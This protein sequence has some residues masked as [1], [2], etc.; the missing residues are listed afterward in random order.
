MKRLLLFFSL[1]FPLNIVISQII[2]V[3]T[4]SKLTS[5]L[6]DTVW[7]PYTSSGSFNADNFFAVQLSNSQGVFSTFTNIGHD[8]A[9]SDSIPMV[10][11]GSGDQWVVR[12]IATDP[13]TISS[14]VSPY[15]RV[16]NYP[17]PSPI[18][19]IKVAAG[20]PTAFVG[21]T[22]HFHD[23]SGEPTGSKFLWT[24][25]QDA[26][27]FVSVDTSPKVTY[28]TIGTKSA[29]LSVSNSTGCTASSSFGLRI[30]T[31]HPIIPDSI[32]IVT[33]TESG[34]FPNVWIKAG[35][36]YIM[37]NGSRVDVTIFAEPGGSLLADQESTGIYYLKTG[38]SFIYGGN[39]R[40][41][42]VILDQ[43]NAIVLNGYGI[44]TLYCNDL[45]FD[46]SKVTTKDVRTEDNP[47]QIVN[48]TNGLRV[49]CEGEVISA[50]VAN[51]LGAKIFSKSDR[52]ILT[53]D[54]SA[55]PD[56]VYFAEISSRDHHEL[57]KIV[58]VH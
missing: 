6:G 47:M 57:R 55:Y 32:H 14:N 9:V 12:I 11:G 13:Y 15:I 2:T 40:P 37:N 52:D 45:Q 33:G 54:L 1:F 35:G 7:V 25:A 31:C 10:I 46:Y 30:L 23:R 17:S 26:N 34:N 56:G 21:D 4:I 44:D 42:T 50:S 51:I 24:F 49:S 29:R 3:G 38:S 48:T 43:G 28:S 18:S 36:N 53:L 41:S 58:V 16:V 8:T 27:I 22:I 39:V 20:I 19:H 5:C